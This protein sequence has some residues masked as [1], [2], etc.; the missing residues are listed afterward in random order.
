[1]I[2]PTDEQIRELLAK[3]K[4]TNDRK[5]IYVCKIALDDGVT[6]RTPKQITEAKKRVA[7]IMR[8]ATD[9]PADFY[10][11]VASWCE[12]HDQH[13]AEGW[14]ALVLDGTYPAAEFRD[15]VLAGREP[16]DARSFSRAGSR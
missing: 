7:A 1:M 2:D 16:R 11:Q 10:L 3:A 9:V 8:D 15:A 5:T 13:P 12:I 4:Q 6:H 14:L